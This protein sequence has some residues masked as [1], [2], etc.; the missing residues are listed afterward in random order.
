MHIGMHH[1]QNFEA[2][3]ETIKGTNFKLVCSVDQSSFTGRVIS[4]LKDGS[5]K[6]TCDNANNCLPFD[7]D[8]GRYQYFSNA[9]SVTVEISAANHLTDSG[10]WKCKL[11]GTVEQDYELVVKTIPT[12][13]NFTQ[14]IPDSNSSEL[15]EN[16][17]LSGRCF[18]IFPPP[19][20]NLYFRVGT[21]AFQFLGKILD[22]FINKRN[23]T[24]SCEPFEYYV[25][26][27][28][29][30]V[31]MKGKTNVFFEMHFDDQKTSDVVGP[32]SFSSK[33]NESSND[34]VG[35]IVGPV[36][37]VIVAGGVA[38]I[39]VIYVKNKE[40][41]SKIDP[42]SR[43]DPKVKEL[44]KKLLDWINHVLTNEGIIVMNIEEDLFDGQI[45]QKLIEKLAG[46]KVSEV[47]QS[48]ED[49]KQNLQ[50]I[51]TEI[52]QILDASPPRVKIKWSVDSVYSK[53]L[54]AI[55][56]LLVALANHFQAKIGLPENV[57]VNLV[58]ETKQCRMVNTSI[59]EEVINPVNGFAETRIEI[60]DRDHGK[61]KPPQSTGFTTNKNAREKSGDS[62]NNTGSKSTKTATER[63][64]SPASASNV[65]METKLHS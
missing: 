9:S 40:E 25:E 33:E 31:E 10:S 21:G 48:G 65:K 45:L 4:L 60:Q 19:S 54:V 47:K 28:N 62:Q 15:V 24:S 51:L 22:P 41:E 13:K 57:S 42:Q 26:V 64:G 2:E 11:G 38:V 32:F 20:V 61:G 30:T 43:N 49:Q 58:V 27:S 6:S 23:E 36:I 50:N 7:S 14:T 39:V 46:L 3:S 53:D 37:A 56:H 59:V 55:L 34:N 63:V 5:T 16:V 8:S 18:C 1:C 44:I 52:N 17:K 12:F 29:F 35:A